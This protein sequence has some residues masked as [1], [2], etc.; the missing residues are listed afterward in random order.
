VPD[1]SSLGASLTEL[2]LAFGQNPLAAIQR[3]EGDLAGRATGREE[4]RGYLARTGLTPGTMH[5]ALEIK[6]VS[7]QINVLVHA[8]GIMTSLPFILEAEEQIQSISLGAGNTGKDFDLETNI[9]VAEFKFV[10]W[11]GGPEAIRQNQ[12]F[13]D[14]LK[15]LWDTSTRRKQLF[16]TGTEEAIRFLRGHRALDSV[17]SRNLHIRSEFLSRYGRKFTRVGEFYQ[18]VEHIVEICDLR[19]LVPHL[20]L[21]DVPPD[22]PPLEEL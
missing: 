10:S 4:I 9:R 7:G 12:V 14:L 15:L 3:L 13:K 19:K 20:G 5:A 18:D 21:A 2:T 8:A 6:R 11:R 17:L 1:N 16:L 22:E